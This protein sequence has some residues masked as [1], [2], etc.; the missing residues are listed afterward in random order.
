MTIDVFAV[1]ALWPG[2]IFISNKGAAL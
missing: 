2:T 1:F